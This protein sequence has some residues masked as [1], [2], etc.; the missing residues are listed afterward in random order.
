MRRTDDDVFVRNVGWSLRTI[1]RLPDR[2]VAG[3]SRASDVVGTLAESLAGLSV[4]HLPF[5]P[6]VELEPAAAPGWRGLAAPL[7][8]VLAMSGN[9][10]APT[11]DFPVA[12][13]DGEPAAAEL[14]DTARR[15]GPWAAAASLLGLS[16]LGLDQAH[17]GMQAGR[18]QRHADSVYGSVVSGP[19]SGPGQRVKLEL[20]VSE[21][22]NRNAESAGGQVRT[23]PLTVLSKMSSVVPADIEVEF[24]SYN[25]DPPNVR[26]RGQGATFETVTRL[27]QL[28]D[29]ETDFSD[30]AVSDVRTAPGGV[31]VVFELRFRIG[32]DSS[33]A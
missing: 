27:Q 4:E 3:G 6:P 12:G 13:H 28:L 17:L 23:S 26:L 31:G 20:R 14:G 18:L 21:L 30:V 19:A 9:L 1:E 33:S 16:A 25:Y 2:I 7:G 5:D 11:I 29:A 15:L 8:L 10:A 24:E 32:S 22:E